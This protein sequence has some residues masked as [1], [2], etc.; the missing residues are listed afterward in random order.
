MTVPQN[1]LKSRKSFTYVSPDVFMVSTKSLIINILQ[2]IV[3]VSFSAPNA[4]QQCGAFSLSCLW[5]FSKFAPVNRDLINRS[6]FC[7]YWSSSLKAY[8]LIVKHTTVLERRMEEHAFT[9]FLISA[10]IA[11]DACFSP[12]K[13]KRVSIRWPAELPFP[14]YCYLC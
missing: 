2:D 6:I 12:A 14:I 7:I 3:R 1:V 9:V 10:S 13:Y 8:S 11:M 4:S 5:I